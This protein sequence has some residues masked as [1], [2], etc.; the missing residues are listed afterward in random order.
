MYCSVSKHDP[1]TLD[2]GTL[3]LGDN[4]ASHGLGWWWHTPEDLIDKIDEKNLRADTQVFADTV[5]T[6]LSCDVLPLDYA[7]HAR[8]FRARLKALAKGAGGRFDVKILNE[9]A[10]ALEA[11]SK[12]LSA[13]AA[14]AK[15][16]K[17]HARINRAL[18]KVS[19]AIVPVDYTKCC[20]FDH[21]P[22]MPAGT[23]PSLEPLAKLGQAPKGSDAEKFLITGLT[24]AKNRVA[25]AYAAA[26]REIEA[27]LKEV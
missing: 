3:S 15:T 10:A 9:R 6:L 8:Y 18:L 21:D 4:M 13:K 20:R 11:A 2:G 22:A 14:M 19:R 17:Q 27:C 23:Y 12:K 7:A 5:W 26:T 1:K 24:R 16:P 25:Y